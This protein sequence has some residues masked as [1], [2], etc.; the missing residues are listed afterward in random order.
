[1]LRVLLVWVGCLSAHPGATG[2][3]VHRPECVI[4]LTS[5]E[6]HTSRQA[7]LCA[8]LVDPFPRLN[9]LER[10]ISLGLYRLLAD[11]IPVSCELLA[12]ALKLP[13]DSINDALNK[14]PGV[15]YDNARR[16]TGY[17]GLALF[18]T[19]HRILVRGKVLY[20]WCAWDSLFVPELL[21]E[22]VQVES[23]CPET[24]RRIRLTVTPQ[25]VIDL[26]PPGVVM[27]WLTPDPAKIR[28][29]VVANFCHYVHF[30][31]SAE[32]GANW[33]WDHQGTFAV[34]VEEAF[35]LGK[36]RNASRYTDG[37]PT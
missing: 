20:T 35:A 24:R 34:T 12:S 6:A 14:W 21:G 5:V 15:W 32:A 26:D 19:A 25:G 18:Q 9:E 17:W 30:F 7:H 37:L 11:G 29:N 23:S 4:N 22:T 3:R 36:T 16:I 33:I 1:L 31:E 28:E 8:T 13:T 27:S 10:R 2:L